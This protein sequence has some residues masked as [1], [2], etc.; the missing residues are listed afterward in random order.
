MTTLELEIEDER[1]EYP[2]SFRAMNTE[3][4]VIIYGED[5]STSTRHELEQAGG[6]VSLLFSQTEERLSRFR[7][8]S[9]LSRLN[10]QGYLREA[11]P[12]L[13]ESV[14]AAL[15]MAELTGGIFDPTILENLEK[16]GYDRSFELLV[17]QSYRTF[18][19]FPAWPTGG[20]YRQIELDPISRNIRLPGGVRIDL[21]GIGKGMTV[22]WASRLLQEAGFKNF[23]VSAGGDMYLSGHP[24]AAPEGWMVGVTNPF[25]PAS[26]LTEIRGHNQAIATSSV[27]KRSWQQGG[28]TRHH[29]IDPRTGKPV[30]NNLAAVTVI[31]P[32]TQ[33]A[34]VL[35]KTA[36]ILG[37]E[38]GKAFIH[39]QPD[40]SA[41]F[42]TTSLELV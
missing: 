27:I 40:C 6:Q 18:D 35:A 17:A 36:L 10:R 21:G 23:V 5:D 19:P 8:E 15:K 14:E 33:L 9:E 26:D 37:P 12:L 13:F 2:L 39:T 29:L 31:A 28:Q 16:A 42:V 32:T 22:D 38:E 20:S 34:D 24:P 7:P 4:E 25:N 1:A 3:I 41:I 11:S 30:V